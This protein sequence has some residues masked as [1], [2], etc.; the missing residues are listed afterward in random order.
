[1][2]LYGHVCVYFVLATSRSW[3][4]RD[5]VRKGRNRRKGRRWNFHQSLSYQIYVNNWPYTN[6]HQLTLIV[7]QSSDRTTQYS[8]N[9]KPTPWFQCRTATKTLS[10]NQPSYTQAFPIPSDVATPIE[11]LLIWTNQPIHSFLVGCLNPCLQGTSVRVGAPQSFLSSFVL[12][13]FY[14]PPLEMIMG[15]C[16]YVRGP[17]LPSLRFPSFLPEAKGCHDFTSVW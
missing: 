4:F 9:P 15:F 3:K 17:P 7:L 10:R 11:F 14:G 5:G 8:L 1:M 13:F 6:F 12:V 16:C 2:S